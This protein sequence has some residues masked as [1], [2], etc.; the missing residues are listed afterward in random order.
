MG[1][2]IRVLGFDTQ[3]RAVNFSIN[4]CVQNGSG[5]HPASYPKGTRE[6]HVK[7]KEESFNMLYMMNLNIISGG[8]GSKQKREVFVNKIHMKLSLLKLKRN[9]N[10]DR[11]HKTYNSLR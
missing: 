3:W 10:H 1:W 8:E 4:H 2:M 9:D 5:A 11:K 7:A 6:F